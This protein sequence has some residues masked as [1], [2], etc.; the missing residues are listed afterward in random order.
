MEKIPHFF[1]RAYK[2]IYRHL[3]K[4]LGKQT[5]A[6]V[7]VWILF[8]S[9]FFLAITPAFANTTPIVSQ[10]P[11]NA[12]TPPPVTPSDADVPGKF[13]FK[14]VGELFDILSNLVILDQLQKTGILIHTQDKTLRFGSEDFL[15]GEKSPDISKLTEQAV[16]VE[17]DL[18]GLYPEYRMP[19]MSL[20]FSMGGFDNFPLVAKAVSLCAIIE[21][22]VQALRALGVKPIAIRNMLEKHYNRLCSMP[23]AR[24]NEMRLNALGRIINNEVMTLVGDILLVQNFYNAVKMT[25]EVSNPKLYELW[26]N[27]TG[28]SS[29]KRNFDAIIEMLNPVYNSVLMGNAVVMIST[30]MKALLRGDLLEDLME[31]KP[32][33]PSA[34]QDVATAFAMFEEA[35][36]SSKIVSEMGEFHVPFVKTIACLFTGR[37]F[38]VKNFHGILY[39]DELLGDSVLLAL[40]CL[41]PAATILR[42]GMVVLSTG[43][44]LGKATQDLTAD[45]DTLP[46]EVKILGTLSLLSAT[47]LLTSHAARTTRPEVIPAR[48]AREPLALGRGNA[49]A[50]SSRKADTH[51]ALQS[52]VINMVEVLDENGQRIF[53]SVEEAGNYRPLNTP[54]LPTGNAPPALQA[55][56][57]G[58]LVNF[59]GNPNTTTPPATQAP[60]LPIVAVGSGNPG[61]IE[62]HG[63]QTT[64]VPASV[65]TPGSGPIVI[66]SAQPPGPGGPGSGNGSGPRGNGSKDGKIIPFSRNGGNGSN[67]PGPDDTAEIIPLGRDGNK[68]PTT[69]KS[70]SKQQY[71]DGTHVKITGIPQTPNSRGVT[72]EVSGDGPA[73][74]SV[75]NA[76]FKAVESAYDIPPNT[77]ILIPSGT[78]DLE[79][80]EVILKIGITQTIPKTTAITTFRVEMIGPSGPLESSELKNWGNLMHLLTEVRADAPRVAEPT[81][82]QM[83]LANGTATVSATQYPTEGSDM[84]TGIITITPGK[85]ATDPLIGNIRQITFGAFTKPIPDLKITAGENEAISP[86]KHI[87]VKWETSNDNGLVITVESTDGTFENA[88]GLWGQILYNLQNS[89]VEYRVRIQDG[90]VEAYLKPDSSFNLGLKAVGDFAENR[91][92]I[93]VLVSPGIPLDFQEFN[94][95]FT[96][97]FKLLERL[98]IFKNR[99][100]SCNPDKGTCVQ[101]GMRGK[102]KS[103]IIEITFAPEIWERNPNL[104][105]RLVN[106][107]KKLNQ[108]E[109]PVVEIAPS[110]TTNGTSGDTGNVVRVNFGNPF[111]RKD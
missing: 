110:T 39:Y 107:F 99:T 48:P 2:R 50:E 19:V 84:F 8:F 26:K 21:Q 59:P 92:A 70:P 105:G 61:P 64:V 44:I 94:G 82:F 69:E 68:T 15:F 90:T 24:L 67:G 52:P 60:A 76:I 72:I 53:V 106:L 3:Y 51:G 86:S 6:M 22:S 97:L 17:L 18:D 73:I 4:R 62:V 40:L 83:T 104:T 74:R 75:R 56:N 102:H 23:I 9:P 88:K 25:V 28:K 7:V 77:L 100:F 93:V 95:I 66:A 43:I 29:F 1:T 35:Y 45:W 11:A 108:P 13:D 91:Q 109:S 42:A 85:P 34:R 101:G 41:G 103:G 38:T 87:R 49:F 16:S 14:T 31:G 10:T 55:D 20:I 78:T 81:R 58:Q 46:K 33:T 98:D 47:L 63:P 27:K 65:P 5:I 57:P 71:I 80:N 12:Q 30:E 96:Q 32:L 111:T 79:I 54:L 89:K 37:E 36:V